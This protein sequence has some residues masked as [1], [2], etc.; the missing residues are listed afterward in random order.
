[1]YFYEESGIF[2]E[3]ATDPPS[4]THDESKAELGSHLMLPSWLEP[5]REEL[6]KTL[7]QWKPVC[8]REIDHET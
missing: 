2:F 5:Q 4:F 3:I 1:M 7:P 6:E 8:W